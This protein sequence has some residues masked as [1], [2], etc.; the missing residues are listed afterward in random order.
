[1]LG[2]YIERHISVDISTYTRLICRPTYWPTLSQYVDQYICRLSVD[3]LR[4]AQNTHDPNKYWPIL[5]VEQ[6]TIVENVN[7]ASNRHYNHGTI[8][9]VYME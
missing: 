6:E 9:R 4:G 8:I 2:R 3:M 7:L 1:M 5:S